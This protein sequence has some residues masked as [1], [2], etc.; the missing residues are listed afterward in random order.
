MTKSAP[1]GVAGFNWAECQSNFLQGRVGMWLD[2]IGF[3]PPLAGIVRSDTRVRDAIRAQTP[4][5]T[6]SPAGTAVAGIAKLAATVDS[7]FADPAVPHT[8]RRA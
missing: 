2:G 6:R 3:A 4:Y 5:L 7:A 1:P 8:A